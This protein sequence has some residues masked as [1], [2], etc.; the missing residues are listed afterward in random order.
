MR[1]ATARVPCE[2]LAACG[3]SAARSWGSLGSGAVAAAA[4]VV[5]G[6]LRP[7]DAGAGTGAGSALAARLPLCSPGS[8]SSAGA[9]PTQR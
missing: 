1:M 4:S 6:V 3:A 2:G 8:V 5:V 9:S 7:E